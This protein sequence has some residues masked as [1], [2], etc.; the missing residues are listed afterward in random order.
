VANDAFE[1][2]SRRTAVEPLDEIDPQEMVSFVRARRFIPG[3][4]KRHVSTATL[5][6]WRLGGL[7]RGCE[8]RE[9]A[10]GRKQWFMPGSEL[11]RLALPRPAAAAE[12]RSLAQKRRDY[13]RALAEARELG[14]IVTTDEVGSAGLNPAEPG[15]QGR[16]PGPGDE[17]VPGR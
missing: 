8:F 7:I 1:K 17:Q 5:H 16:R 12:V 9:T 13:E 4:Q 10:S 14:L 3:S 6:R 2:Q 15:R 11:R